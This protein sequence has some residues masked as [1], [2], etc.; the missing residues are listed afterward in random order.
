VE[1][2]GFAIRICAQSV[3]AVTVAM[4]RGCS[5]GQPF[6]KKAPGL[7]EGDPGFLATL[8]D[9]GELDLSV[10]GIEDRV[11]RLALRKDR[12]VLPVG[13]EC[14]AGTD[15]GEKRVGIEQVLGCH[16]HPLA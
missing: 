9:D 13:S 7:Q 12:A 4:R 3:S 14:S 10:L 16:I 8:G 1:H 5:A 2:T 15:V 11:D 6:P